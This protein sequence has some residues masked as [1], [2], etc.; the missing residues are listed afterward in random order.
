MN[1]LPSLYEIC[2]DQGIEYPP[3]GIIVCGSKDQSII[4]RVCLYNQSY[5]CLCG[6]WLIKGGELHH[7]LL[8]KK[9][10]QGSKQKDMIHHTCNCIVLCHKCHET[11]NRGLSIEYLF[12]VYGT[13]IVTAWYDKMALTFK[14]KIRNL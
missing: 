12:E 7:A 8:S 4:K 13:D 1:N 9:D 3:K 5:N 2:V 14:S 11:I 10:V 6:E